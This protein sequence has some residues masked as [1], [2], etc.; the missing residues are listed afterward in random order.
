MSGKSEVGR[1]AELASGMKVVDLSHALEEH[2]PSAK[3]HSRYFHTLWESFDTG[4]IALAYQLIMNEH[5]GT[6]M[7]ATAH[8]LREDHPAHQYMDETPATQFFGRALTLDFTHYGE[9]DLVT[10]AELEDWERRNEP[11]RS[12][13]IVFFYFGWDRYWAPR[14]VSRKFSERW[15]GIGGEAA[16]WLVRRGVKVVGC[17]TIAID[18]CASPDAP[19]HYILLGNRVNIVENLARL[20]EIVGESFVVIAPLKV[21]RGSAGPMRALAFK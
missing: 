12:G 17:D 3:S 14:T 8:F 10:V 9:L 6:H 15:P 4:S 19:A 20:S 18:G 5:T 7:D 1:M 16:E 13:D 21:K 2:M 11:I